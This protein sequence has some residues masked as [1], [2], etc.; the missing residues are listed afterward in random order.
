VSAGDRRLL[1]A[2]QAYA[3]RRE[4]WQS[5][6]LAGQNVTTRASH[7][8]TKTPSITSLV[9]VL[10]ALAPKPVS[11]ERNAPRHRA[12]DSRLLLP[13]GAKAFG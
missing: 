10:M 12:S 9:L 13:L 4:L 2:E 6:E 8:R 7:R 3:K 1:S 5:T 11:T